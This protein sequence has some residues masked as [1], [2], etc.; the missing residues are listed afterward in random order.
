MF[1]VRVTRL[2]DGQTATAQASH[3]QALK[4]HLEASA[5][6]NGF[7]VVELLEFSWRY[8]SIHG[9]IVRVRDGATVATYEIGESK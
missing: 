5:A 4:D 3:R 7:E 9:E 6:R 1:E 2:K 8:G